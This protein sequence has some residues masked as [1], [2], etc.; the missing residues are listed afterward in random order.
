MIQSN[1]ASDELDS[2]FYQ[3]NEETCKKWEHFTH[4]NNGTISGT[5]NAW[6]Y[7]LFVK[8]EQPNTCKIT[9]SKATY[10]SGNLL[11]SSKYQ[12]RQEHLV[13]HM[14]VASKSSFMIKRASWRE[15]LTQRQSLQANPYYS[16]FGKVDKVILTE[17]VSILSSLF[18]SKRVNEVHLKDGILNIKLNDSNGNLDIIHSLI[19]L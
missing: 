6:S 12:N 14:K 4:Q 1:A 10:S 11:L 17:I 2:P 18:E 15:L 13:F 9:V 19:Q 3:K 5:Y 7:K 16:I 8:F